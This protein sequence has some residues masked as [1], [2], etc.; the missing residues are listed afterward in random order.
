MVGFSRRVFV[1]ASTGV[2]AAAAGSSLAHA[3]VQIEPFFGSRPAAA[4]AAELAASEKFHQWKTRTGMAV[5]YRRLARGRALHSRL[6]AY[7]DHHIGAF[8]GSPT[9][10][11]VVAVTQLMSQRTVFAGLESCNEAFDACSCPRCFPALWR[12]ARTSEI[13][14]P[15]ALALAIRRI[16]ASR[17]MVQH[18]LPPAD[19]RK[20]YCKFEEPG[21]RPA[22]VTTRYWT[23]A[24]AA[25]PEPDWKS[26]RESARTWLAAN[27]RASG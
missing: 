12:A 11:H 14:Q 1:A 21:Q 19:A 4:D 9:A 15:G 22:G 8:G 7:I 6:L 17:R 13:E 24:F 2:A 10:A 26:L 27:V 5:G 23:L 25:P 16:R 20:A 18:A 3:G